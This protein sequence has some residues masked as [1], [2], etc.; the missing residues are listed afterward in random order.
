[1]LDQKTIVIKLGTSTLTCGS[2]KL[3]RAH[4]L[5]IVRAVF[6]LRQKGYQV[7]LV[8]SGAIAA[9]REFL[10]EPNLPALMSVKQML[11][12]VGQGKLIEIYESLFSIYDLKI[13]QILLT[14]A[15]VENRERF[16]NARDALT[17]LLE[18]DIVPII[19]ENDAVS[20]Q[21]IRVGDNDYMAALAGILC[22]ADLIVL[23]TDQKGLYTDNPRTNPQATL[24]SEVSEITD[25]IEK[26]AGGAGTSLGTG[27]MLTKIKA[28]KAATQAG[29]EL[30]IASGDNPE[31]LL[32]LVEGHGE[33]TYFR[34]KN[35]VRY[36]KKTWLSVAARSQGTIVVDEGAVEAL[37]KKGS[38]LLPKGIVGVRNDFLRGAIVAIED[39]NGVVI[40]QGLSRYSS[41]ELNLILGHRSNEIEDILG[42]SHGPVAVHRDDLVLL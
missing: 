29:I 6:L 36:A 7:V 10:G 22:E 38:S 39:P 34:A 8:S 21:E 14:R 26:I 25:E 15:D 1:M 3:N 2:D 24:I 27:G 23:L 33:G 41:E 4:M 35:G 28:A 19:N 11:A 40:A 31:I 17:A 9:G 37:V 20:T 32:D 13:G 18:H 42:F 12:A 30:V 16:L 5:E